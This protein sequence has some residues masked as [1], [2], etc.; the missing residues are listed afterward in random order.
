MNERQLRIYSELRKDARKTL[1]EIGA[2]TNMPV[3]T[4]FEHLRQFEKKL[5]PRYAALLDFNRLRVIRAN[6]VVACS[7]KA[8]V[9]HFLLNHKN[10]NSVFRIN[11]NFDFFVEAA[12]FDMQQFEQ[13]CD[14]L[15]GLKAKARIHFVV[16][17]MKKECFSQESLM[18]FLK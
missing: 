3:S 18:S 16:E 15:S 7:K 11:N 12:F 5:N 13:F 10:T 1:S 4:V 8:E 9:R 6:F 17:T 2:A 14:G